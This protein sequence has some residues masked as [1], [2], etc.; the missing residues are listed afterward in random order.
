MEQAD[1]NPKPFFLRGRP[2]R[3]RMV[4]LGDIVMGKQKG[5]SAPDDVT[6]FCSVGLAGAEVV[7]AD[8][9]LRECSGAG[10]YF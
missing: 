5:R 7:V 3:E 2:E 4:E 1:A 9:A 8:L 10:D 6:L